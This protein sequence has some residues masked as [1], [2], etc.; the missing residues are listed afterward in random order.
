MSTNK[1][2][3]QIAN[4]NG[5]TT[6]QVRAELREAIENSKTQIKL[7][8]SGSSAYQRD[9]ALQFARSF[10]EIDE[11]TAQKILELLKRSNND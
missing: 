7:N 9:A 8:L 5:V 11:N 6:S 3:K 4:K 1:I 10:G 2:I